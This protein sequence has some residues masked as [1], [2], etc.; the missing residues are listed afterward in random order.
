MSERYVKFFRKEIRRQIGAERKRNRS[1]FQS[2]A[3]EIQ[4][5]VGKDTTRSS[6]LFRR[7]KWL[8]TGK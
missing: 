7:L 1:T 3:D 4:R 5:A 6:S 8:F 2:F